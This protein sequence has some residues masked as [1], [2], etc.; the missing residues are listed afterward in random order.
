MFLKDSNFFNKII[1]Y[2]ITKEYCKIY[3]QVIKKKKKTLI[4]K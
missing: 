2:I 3:T 4:P 1:M